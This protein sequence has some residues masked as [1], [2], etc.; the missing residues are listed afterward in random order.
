MPTLFAAAASSAMKRIALPLLLLATPCQRSPA[1]RAALPLPVFSSPP[2]IVPSPKHCHP[3]LVLCDSVPFSSPL[4][5][6]TA[7]RSSARR[8]S[9][10]LRPRISF[11]RPSIAIQYLS[12]AMRYSAKAVRYI[13]RAMPGCA[14]PCQCFAMRSNAAA[15]LIRSTPP[16]RSSDP[17]RFPA[18]RATPL[19]FMTHPQRFAAQLCH[20]NSLPMRGESPPCHCRSMP[21]LRSS[22]P[23]TSRLRRHDACQCHSNPNQGSSIAMRIKTSPSLMLDLFPY[24]S[25]ATGIPPLSESVILSV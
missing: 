22:L 2:H 1:Q 3:M 25:T 16:P 20:Y 11:H 15:C 10:F 13:A 18:V 9:S 23:V 17:L 19:H 5:S 4:I 21:Q 7:L 12:I 24:E 14:F 8:C 6:S